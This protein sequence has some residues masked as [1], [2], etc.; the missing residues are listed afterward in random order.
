[1][2]SSIESILAGCLGFIWPVWES[3]DLA[4]EPQ[5]GYFKLTD[6]GSL[7]IDSLIEDQTKRFASISPRGF[8]GW[9]LGQT[10]H[11]TVL[12]LN[13]HRNSEIVTYGGARASVASYYARTLIS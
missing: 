11:S 5:R 6:D 13:I 4:N 2:P 1:M 9:I 10:E 3:G 12:A 7:K 8:P